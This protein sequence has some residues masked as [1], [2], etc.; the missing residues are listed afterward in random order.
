MGIPVPEGD[1]ILVVGWRISR[2]EAD[3]LSHVVGA[4]PR[5]L[6]G[7]EQIGDLLVTEN[8]SFAAARHPRTAAGVDSAHG[9]LWLAGVDGR[10][11]GYSDGMSLPELA[12]LMKALGATEAVN[13]DGGGSTVM[14]IRGVAVNRPSDEEGERAVVNALA[15]VRDPHLCRFP[16]E[17]RGP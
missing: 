15:V 8:P 6:E 9:T 7:G 11:P 16:G 14:V 10:Q 13:L 17:A 1:S 12:R 5:L 4:Y 2:R 3:G